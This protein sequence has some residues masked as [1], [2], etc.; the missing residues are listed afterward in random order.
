[1]RG[2]L[3]AVVLAGCVDAELE[4]STVIADDREVGAACRLDALLGCRDAGDACTW[5]APVGA[6][7]SDAF[8]PFCASGLA[9]CSESVCRPFCA[10]TS[11]PRC[12]AGLVERHEKDGPRDVCVCAPE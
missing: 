11:F 6:S 9:W 4:V 3:I 10:V 1:M 7:C 5:C 12:G 2:L 8:T